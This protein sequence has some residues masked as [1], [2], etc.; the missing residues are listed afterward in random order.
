[1]GAPKNQG[2]DTFSFLGPL[3]A[4]L[5]PAGGELV[6]PAPGTIRLVLIKKTT[7]EL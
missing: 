1:M 6:P 5:D 7:L 2:E 4:I 3:A